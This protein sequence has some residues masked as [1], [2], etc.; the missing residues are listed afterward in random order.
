MAPM[1]IRLQLFLNLQAKSWISY[2]CLSAVCL[3]G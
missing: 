1:T 2:N 3:A